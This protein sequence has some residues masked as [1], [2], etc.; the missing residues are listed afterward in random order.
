MRAVSTS[1]PLGL[2]V[3]GWRASAPRKPVLWALG[4]VG[5][6][7]AA[8]VSVGTAMS[9][10]TELRG[11][12]IAGSTAITLGFL[13][14]GLFTWAQRPDNAVGLLMVAVAYA[15][16]L[17][18]LVFSNSDVLFSVG[19]MVS[20]LF[21][22]VTVHLLL[23]FPTGQFQGRLDRA[24]AAA[25][26]F[27]ATVVLVA[28]NAFAAPASFD[29][30]GCP[31]NVFLIADNKSLAETLGDV[32]SV[33]FAAVALGSLVSLARRWLGATPVQRRALTAV[34]FAGG[35]LLVLLFAATTIIPLFGADVEVAAVLAIAA[36]VPFGLVPY[37]LLV[38]LIRS[39]VIR[40]GAFRDLVAGLNETRRPGELRNALAKALGDPS[41]KLAYWL[42]ESGGYVDVEGQ[43]VEL[44]GEGA[45][46][47]VTEVRVDDRLVAA[48]EH[49]ASLL[50]DRDQ[51]RAV[52]AAAGLALENERLDAE[53]R[54]KVKELRASRTRMMEEASAERRRLERDLHDGAQQRLVSL[55]LNLRIAERRVEEDPTVA[56]ELLEAAGGELEA[57]MGELRELAR[58]IHPAI[59]SDRGLGP[60]LQALT[61]R[62]PLPVDLEAVPAERLPDPVELAGYF[63]VAEALTNVARYAQ[64][65]SARVR[66]V[67][68]KGRLVIEVCDDGI[69][70][71]DPAKG[72]GL[73][74]L[75]DRLA[76]VDGTLGVKSEVGSGT[77]LRAEVRCSPTRPA[78][79]AEAVSNDEL[80]TPSRNT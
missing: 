46:R 30:Q 66:A 26:Y 76:A 40:G 58:G 31:E 63:V 5:V 45:H 39:R 29:C 38:S 16:V 79:S 33:I 28:A 73:R 36:L 57:A 4:V 70:G 52:G 44:P 78:P 6:G 23:V 19:I 56:R 54:A 68:E 65:K 25:A 43:P 12:W 67:Y 62:A 53:L 7:I 74:G 47:A 11:L 64:A 75:S 24:T 18:D 27:A 41:V 59:L 2:R 3:S 72:S 32:G 69:G 10:H 15:W 17:S 37:V 61:A 21:I 1:I 13:G 50:D 51:V 60:A 9:V 34:L 80:E 49:D 22:A 48:I 20:H 8:A 42:P 71:A 77:T 35:A 14:A 55:A